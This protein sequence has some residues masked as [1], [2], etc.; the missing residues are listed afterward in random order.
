MAPF[1]ALLLVS[2]AQFPSPQR[3]AVTQGMKCDWGSVVSV[4]PA[5][6]STLVVKTVAGPVTYQLSPDTLVLGVDKEP[7]DIV[8]LKPETRVRIYYILD[9]G[10]QVAEIDLEL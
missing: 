10:P 7:R 9:N 6:H 3:V 1:L 5:A 4:K 2:M 8:A